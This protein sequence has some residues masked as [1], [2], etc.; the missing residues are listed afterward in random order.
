MKKPK[1]GEKKE[2][3]N[4]SEEKGILKGNLLWWSLWKVGEGAGT[5]KRKGKRGREGNPAHSSQ[6]PEGG[7]REKTNTRRV[8]KVQAKNCRWSGKKE[9]TQEREVKPP[10]K[11]IQMRECRRLNQGAK[12]PDPARGRASKKKS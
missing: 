4:L 2:A 12:P 11:K 7:T 10:N 8:K 9:K 6:D 5:K 1:E 3:R